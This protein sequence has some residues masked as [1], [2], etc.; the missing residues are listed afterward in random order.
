MIRRWRS[1]YGDKPLHLLSLLACFGLT[2]YAALQASR[3]PNAARMLVWF[4]GAIVA[5]DLVLYPLYALRTVRSGPPSIV[6]AGARSREIRP[7]S[8]TSV[9]PSCCPGS[10]S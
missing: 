5:H 8:T 6:M 9:C 7:T 3:A 2:G 10:P 1:F 4:V